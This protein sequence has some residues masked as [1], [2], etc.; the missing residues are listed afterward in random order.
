MHFIG[1]G[2]SDG[3]IHVHGNAGRHLGGEMTG[4]RIDVEGDAG[5][6]VGGEMHGGLI[7]VNGQRGTSDRRGLPGQPAR[8]DRR[9]DPDRRR[10]RS[11]IG[12]AMRRGIL[13]VGGSCGDVAGFNMIAGSIFVFGKLRDPDRRGHAP[14]DHRTFRTRSRPSCFPPFDSPA[15][16]R[17][18]FLRLYFRELARLGFPVDEGLL[19]REMLLYHGDLVGLGKGEVWMPA[20]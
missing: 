15:A 10:R 1:Y 19:D 18:L 8:D 5:D 13:A 14:R 2:M 16:I 20:V 11:E 3:E 4:G 6:W 12:G 7:Q 17:P 9:H